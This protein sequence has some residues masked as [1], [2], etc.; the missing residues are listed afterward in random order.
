LSQS[1]P[2]SV[3][4]ANWPPGTPVIEPEVSSTMS[5]LALCSCRSI[6]TSGLTRAWEGATAKQDQPTIATTMA[7]A[8]RRGRRALR[9]VRLPAAVHWNRFTS[10][11]IDRN[12]LP[13]DVFARQVS[14]FLQPAM[15][16]LRN[17]RRK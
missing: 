12:P 1:T 3:E 13:I 7:A 9:N 8:D 5:M 17:K 2:T 14:Y 15:T 16:I 10:G 4:L 11:F 6:T